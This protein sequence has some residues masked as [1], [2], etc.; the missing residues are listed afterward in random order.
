MVVR[1]R[2]QL[3]VALEKLNFNLQRKN[4]M[5]SY[6]CAVIFFL[7]RFIRVLRVSAMVGKKTFSGRYN[8]VVVM[9]SYC[10]DVNQLR[11]RHSVTH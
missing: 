9:K 5:I 7:V 10:F 3:R 11:S 4:S 2:V 8:K 6:I 1:V